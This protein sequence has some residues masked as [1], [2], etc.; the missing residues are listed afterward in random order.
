METQ[1]RV[2]RR[3]NELNLKEGVYVSR[4]LLGKIRSNLIKII[5]SIQSLRCW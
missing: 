2:E 3:K 5:V 1:A 4:I